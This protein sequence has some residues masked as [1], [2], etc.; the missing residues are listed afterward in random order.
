MSTLAENTRNKRKIK[1][2]QEITIGPHGKETVS[3]CRYKKQKLKEE[4]LLQQVNKSNKLVHELLRKS[5]KEVESVKVYQS[6]IIVSWANMAGSA[7]SVRDKVQ[8][9][10]KDNKY[11]EDESVKRRFYDISGVIS[12]S[13]LE[14]K[15][16]I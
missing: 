4:L 15:G 8:G 5:D 9:N 10:S 6:D 14:T 7:K 11:T 2:G 3:L 12:T 16:R 13:Q 1:S